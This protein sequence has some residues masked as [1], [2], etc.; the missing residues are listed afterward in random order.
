MSTRHLVYVGQTPAEGT[1]SPVILLRHLRRLAQH[2]WRITIVAEHGQDTTACERA[3]WVVRHLPHRGRYWP[4]YRPQS[5][6]RIL[7]TIRTWLL[8]RECRKACGPTPPD[9]ILGYLAAHADF[10][11][12][13][14]AHFAAQ[15]GAP[16]TLLVHDDAA[17]FARDA[18]ETRQ[19]RA[20]HAWIIR[21]THRCWFVSPE[22]AEVYNVPAAFRRVLFPIPEGWETPAA[23]QPMYTVKPRVYY[24]GFVWP[25]QYPL[26]TKLA[27]TLDAAGARLALLTRDTPEL[28]RFLAAEPADWIKQFPTNRE[29]L[30]HLVQNA[31]GLLVSYAE[32][33]EEMPWV[34]TSY[35][36][37]FV[38]YSHLGIPCAI[39]APEDSAIGR[40]SQRTHYPLFFPPGALI[41]FGAWATALA[42]PERWREFSASTLALARGEFSPDVIQTQFEQDLVRSNPR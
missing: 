24:A 42:Q 16:F 38:E 29:A 36:S 8:A 30:H 14:A 25:P 34:A 39:V 35:P 5:R 4:P 18:A 33:S 41:Q 23:F 17:A 12:E 9:A 1:G 20:R 6:S 26:L 15:S 19:L 21:Q 13:I 22:L 40:W 3:G 32:K 10:S 2:G 28:Q 11:P 7:R 27:R 37:K 31:A